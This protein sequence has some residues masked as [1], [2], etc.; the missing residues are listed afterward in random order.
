[1]SHLLACALIIAK[2]KCAVNT[3]LKNKMFEKS[4]DSTIVICYYVFTTQRR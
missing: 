3:I 1:M 2:R 4:V